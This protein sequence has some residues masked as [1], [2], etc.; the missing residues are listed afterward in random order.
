MTFKLADLKERQQRETL[1]LKCQKNEKNEQIK[2]FFIKVMP[3]WLKPKLLER[4]YTDTI[5]QLCTLASPQIAI[6]ENC[7][8]EEYFDDGLTE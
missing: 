4:P 5:D 1:P 2:R 6:R 8:R 3:S 7:N